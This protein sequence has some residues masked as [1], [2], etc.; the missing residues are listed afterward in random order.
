MSWAVQQVF[1]DTVP[2]HE[3]YS[4]VVDGKSTFIYT[5]IVEGPTLEERWETLSTVDEMV[6]IC[7]N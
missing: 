7:G 1:H 4:L 6:D 2:V 5:Q 3:V